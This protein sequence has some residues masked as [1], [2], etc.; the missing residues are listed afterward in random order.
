M[1]IVRRTLPTLQYALTRFADII[2][3]TFSHSFENILKQKKDTLF[4]HLLI[5]TVRVFTTTNF[6]IRAQSGFLLSLYGLPEK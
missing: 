4:F 2:S 6:R 3:V 5:P 1:L